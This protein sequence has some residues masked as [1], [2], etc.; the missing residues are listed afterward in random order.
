MWRLFKEKVRGQLNEVAPKGP[1]IKISDSLDKKAIS[2]L[3]DRLIARA[4]MIIIKLLLLELFHH[5]L[6]PVINIQY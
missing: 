6:A 5:S 1:L 2:N 3:S 4:R